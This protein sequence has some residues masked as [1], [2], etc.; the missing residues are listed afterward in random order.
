MDCLLDVRVDRDHALVEVWV[1]PHQ[2]LGVPSH[3]DKN[4]INPTGQ[5]RSE[6]IT[7][8]QSDQEGEGDDYRC[9]CAVRVV[10]WRRE[11]EVEIRKECASVCYESGAHGKHRADQAFIYKRIDSAFLDHST[12]GQSNLLIGD[13]VLCRLDGLMTY[14][15]VAFAAET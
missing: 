15:Q 2:H 12:S 1:F 11:D 10:C 4:R 14:F 6:D 8:L 9:V 3:G 5:R 13:Q 7:D